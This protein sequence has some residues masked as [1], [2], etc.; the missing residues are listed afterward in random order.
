MSLFTFSFR[1]PLAVLTAVGVLAFGLVVT[2][3][4]AQADA[5]TTV[6]ATGGVSTEVEASASVWSASGA[7]TASID[8]EATATASTP[9]V[10]PPEELSP[11]GANDW[12]C[13][14]TSA[15]PDPVILVP[16]TFESMAKNWSTLSP[17]LKNQGY[18]V[19]AL[20]YGTT[21]GIDATGPI[22]DSARELS[23]FVDRVLAASGA[24]QADIVGHSQGG[25]MPRYYLG[26]LG[27]ADKV[28]AL[29]GIAPSNH[30]TEG[31]ITP[32]PE[33]VPISSGD[34]DVVCQACADQEAGS[35]FLTELN[36]I[37]DLVDGPSYT[38]ISTKFDEV[39][40]PYQSQFLAGPAARVTNITIQDL[41]PADPIEHDQAPNDP[42]VHQLVGNALEQKTGRPAD[43][44]FSPSCVPLG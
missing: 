16:G 1:E 43:A 4:P 38:V 17:Y 11:P 18:C 35:P 2:T 10:A 36:S 42:V 6:S 3:A 8:V 29:V 15:H 20:N 33:Q 19:Y 25:M 31:L 27:G 9:T 30:G 34:A 26:F 5:A 7:V 21:N 12:T 39:V 37:G 22:A 41:C 28:D 44:A 23:A 24:D 40:T 14:P 13:V 32:T